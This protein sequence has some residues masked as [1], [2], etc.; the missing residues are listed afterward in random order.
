MRSF[1]AR[2][3]KASYES[4]FKTVYESPVMPCSI[5]SVVVSGQTQSAHICRI[6]KTTAGATGTQDGRAANEGPNANLRRRDGETR[7]K[8]HLRVLCKLKHRHDSYRYRYKISQKTGISTKC[9]QV[10]M[11]WLARE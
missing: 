9:Q 7:T 6:R 8:V 2:A 4:S 1:H 11:H 10:Y 5:V 3:K